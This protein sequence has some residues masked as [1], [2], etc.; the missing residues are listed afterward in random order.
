MIHRL[1]QNMFNLSCQCLAK[2]VV[3]GSNTTDFEWIKSGVNEQTTNLHLAL[4][5]EAPRPFCF[6]PIYCFL[7]FCMRGT[8]SLFP[9]DEQFVELNMM[10]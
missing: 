3:F 6:R 4:I 5:R 10:D 2:S 9:S 7:V 1:P 8:L